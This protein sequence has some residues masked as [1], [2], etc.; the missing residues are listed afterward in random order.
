MNPAEQGSVDLADLISLL[1]RDGQ[2]K[3]ARRPTAP[4]ASPDTPYPL[5]TDLQQLW[6]KQT[7]SIEDRMSGVS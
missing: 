2:R 7:A 4:A 6:K 5:T 3:A 1:W